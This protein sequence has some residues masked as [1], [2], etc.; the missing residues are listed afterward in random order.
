MANKNPTN[1]FKKGNPGG[2]GRPKDPDELK[3]ITKMTKAEFELLMNKLLNLTKD[4]LKQWQGTALEQAM[5]SII[6]KAIDTGD[7]FRLQFFIERLFGKVT[8]KVE[9]T[10]KT[11]IAEKIKKFKQ[12]GK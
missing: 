2:P 12:H 4:E 5:C 7:Q 3:L 6:V 1:G 10:D 8:D 9:F 11:G